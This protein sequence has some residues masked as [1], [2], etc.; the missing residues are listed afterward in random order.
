MNFGSLGGMG[1]AVSSYL[2]TPEG[3]EAAKQFL[4]SPEGINLLK[5]FAAS[6]EGQK[7]LLSVVP[8]LLNVINL[9][10]G[11]KEMILAGLPK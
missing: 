6:P 5:T 2:G 9:P 11:V 1:G 10:P 7:A 8:T 3:Q 4:A